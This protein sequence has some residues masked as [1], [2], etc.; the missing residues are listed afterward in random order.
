MRMRRNILYWVAA[1]LLLTACNESLEDTYSDFAGDGKIRY[2]LNVR[3]FMPLPV[4]RG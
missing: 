1:V 4:G 3:K 2:G